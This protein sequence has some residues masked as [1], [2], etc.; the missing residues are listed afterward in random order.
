MSWSNRYLWWLLVIAVTALIVIYF[1]LSGTGIEMS[2][3]GDVRPK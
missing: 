3:Q 2:D 1:V